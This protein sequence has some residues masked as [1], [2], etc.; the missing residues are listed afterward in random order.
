MSL[1]INY[2]QIYNILSST[3]FLY[4]RLNCIFFFFHLLILY[5]LK[6]LQ[7]RLNLRHSSSEVAQQ[8]KACVTKLNDLNSI[9][10]TYSVEGEN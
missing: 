5:L 9:P 3:L 6:T 2:R 7:H 4:S 8:G 10:R 1:L